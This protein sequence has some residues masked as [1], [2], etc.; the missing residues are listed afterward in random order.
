MMPVV[1]AHDVTSPCTH[2][3]DK[4]EDIIAH[5]IQ[6]QAASTAQVKSYSGILQVLFAAGYL[7]VFIQQHSEDYAPGYD[8]LLNPCGCEEQDDLPVLHVMWVKVGSTGAMNHFIPLVPRRARSRHKAHKGKRFNL[9]GVVENFCSACLGPLN[10]CQA[11]VFHLDTW[12][13]WDVCHGWYHCLC[14]GLSHAAAEK[15]KYQCCSLNCS[16]SIAKLEGCTI[17]VGD[18]N[19]V[20]NGEDRSGDAID[21]FMRLLILDSL[22]GFLSYDTYHT[23]HRFVCRYLQLVACSASNNSLMLEESLPS[24]HVPKLWER[25]SRLVQPLP[26]I[27]KRCHGQQE[28]SGALPALR[29]RDQGGGLVWTASRRLMF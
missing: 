26:V 22:P 21:F 25:I 2:S 24:L 5:T 16:T 4:L 9:E 13:E 23:L 29:G 27:G 15:M 10:M 6:D 18:I 11:D 7:G 3:C 1:Y 12:V 8:T 17:S 20:R 14:T 19:R 28:Q